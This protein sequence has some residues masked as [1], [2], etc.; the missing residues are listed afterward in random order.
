MTGLYNLFIRIYGGLVAVAALFNQKANLRFNGQ[1]HWK[2]YPVDLF[3]DHR[4]IWIHCASV[5][6]FEQARPIIESIGQ[7]R[8]DIKIVVTFYSP[9]GYEARKNYKNAHLVTY[10]PL[11]TKANAK[12]FIA[13]LNP[14]LALF[15]KYELWINILRT[16]KFRNIPVALVSAHFP[17]K[18][19][20]LR[21]SAYGK[22]LRIFDR[23]FL[24]KESNIEQ[25]AHLGLDNLY[26]SGDTR[27]DRVMS[28]KQN[29]LKLPEIKNWVGDSESLVIGSCWP[30]D[31]HVLKP[32]IEDHDI[33]KIIVAPH[34]IDDQ[35]WQ[36]WRSD[37]EG[38]IERLS[39]VNHEIPN[40]VRIL[41]VDKV[42][43]LSSL[44][45]FATIA[46]VGGGFSKAV[47]N[48]LEAS[49]FGI[50]VL[51][52]PNNTRFAEIQELK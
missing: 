5:G 43:L 26:V 42:G 23:I 3:V 48:T 27:F 24:Q 29:P 10:L 46:Y 40:H 13:W 39:K 2:T 28:V 8:P 49:V 32:M 6:E 1:N 16:L 33:P 11:D 17:P 4:P 25:L 34:E 52:G 35:Q 44:Y 30:S 22:V 7:S 50:P 19:P 31:H 38:S 12:E 47:H 15:V 36:R 20:V 37:F 41:Y 9:S 21:F 51:F 18:H 14:Q 45:Q